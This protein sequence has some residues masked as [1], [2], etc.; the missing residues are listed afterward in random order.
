MLELIDWQVFL[1]LLI[2]G[3]IGLYSV[4]PLTQAIQQPT[5]RSTAKLSVISRVVKAGIQL[6]FLSLCIAGGMVV[7]RHFGVSG[8]PLIEAALDGAL[9]PDLRSAVLVPILAGLVLGAFLAPL[10]LHQ[11]EEPHVDFYKIAIWKRLLA[12]VLHGGI[13]EEIAFRWCVLAS[14]A[15][16]LGNLPGFNLSA[17]P[18]NTFWIANAIAALLFG[19]AH[20]PGNAAIAPLTI[21]VIILA[22][23]L[24]V[25]VG[26]VYGYFFWVSGLEAAMLAHMSTHVALQPCTSLLLRFQRIR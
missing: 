19:L 20:L 21:T 8:T 2:A 1:V 24:N 12:G 13:V 3:Y 5:T 11:P 26:L 25:L 6:A 18:N 17:L 22:I 16:L 4:H 23:V 7:T 15:W 10:L 14:I 9:L